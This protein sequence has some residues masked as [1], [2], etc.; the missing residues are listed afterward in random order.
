M[1][2]AT[3][4]SAGKNF[5][6]ILDFSQAYFCVQTAD[7]FSVQFL[8][9][10]FTPQTFAYNYLAQGVNKAVKGFS[11]AVMHYC[12]STSAKPAGTRSKQ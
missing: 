2:G 8:T 3:N 4:Y 10:I 12:R 7:N 6:C 11:S 9:F 5:F 1:T